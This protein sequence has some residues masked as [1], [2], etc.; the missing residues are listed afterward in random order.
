M[1]QYMYIY[2]FPQYADT[3]QTRIPLKYG[4]AFLCP[5]CGNSVQ[6]YP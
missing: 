3:S 6:N 4:L 1:W 5:N 2:T